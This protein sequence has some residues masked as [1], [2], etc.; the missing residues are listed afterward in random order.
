MKTT[1]KFFKTLLATGCIMLAAHYGYS[2]SNSFPASGNVGINTLTPLVELD[3]RGA[4]SFNADQQDKDF[5][6]A[7]VTK[8]RLVIVDAATGRVGIGFDGGGLPGTTLDVNGIINTNTAYTL[9]GLNIFGLSSGFLSIASQLP[10]G[11]HS[12]YL[13]AGPITVIRQATLFT[14]TNA[15]NEVGTITRGASGQTADLEQ[16]QTVDGTRLAVVDANGNFGI[17]TTAPQTKLAVNGTITTKKIE[18]TLDGWADYVFEEDYELQPLNEVE[19]FVK[20]NKH[21][22]NVPSEEEML[23][24]PVDL[25]ATD[26]MLIR[27][28]EELTLYL[29]EQD[30]TI[31]LQNKQLGEQAEI[32]ETLKE[33]LDH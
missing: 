15:A 8:S 20:A 5:T 30:K 32:L 31:K 1:N 18:V 2:Q 23:E 17:G 22:P 27:K 29:I 21:L 3:V 19:A 14:L 4:A 28:I 9:G 33:Q 16:W 11:T 24:N 25:G 10:N 6:V 7:G 12:A 13:T 26:A